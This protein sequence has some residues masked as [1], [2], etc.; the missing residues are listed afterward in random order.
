MAP[1]P[2][3]SRR[4]TVPSRG[5][6]AKTISVSPFMPRLS[7]PALHESRPSRIQPGDD[8]RRDAHE[9]EREAGQ[10]ARGAAAP[11]IA[12]PAL[13]RGE[14]RDRQGGEAASPQPSDQVD[15]L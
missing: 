7:C 15:I 1:T 13:G 12:W 14:R 11:A 5:A 8:A 3:A 4:L 6:R 10:V 9:P 2:A